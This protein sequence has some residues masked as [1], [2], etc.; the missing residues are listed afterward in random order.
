L[1]SFTYNLVNQGAIEGG[2]R[3]ILAEIALYRNA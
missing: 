3:D 2:I 1:N